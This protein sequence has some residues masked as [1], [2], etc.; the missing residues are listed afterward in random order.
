VTLP[1]GKEGYNLPTPAIKALENGK[2]CGPMTTT[3]NVT[4]TFANLGVPQS[5][6]APQGAVGY[7]GKG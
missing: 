6:T 4:V 3:S 5:V 2:K 7:L 1:N